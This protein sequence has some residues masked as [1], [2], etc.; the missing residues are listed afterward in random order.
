MY[1]CDNCKEV[2]N[3]GESLNK[4]VVETRQVVYENKVEKGKGVDKTIKEFITNGTEIV[5]EEKWCGECYERQEKNKKVIEI[6]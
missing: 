1:K 6:N 5:K 3:P 2:S 4:V